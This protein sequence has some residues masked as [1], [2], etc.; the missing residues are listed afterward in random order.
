MALI[1]TDEAA[2]L[3]LERLLEEAR[4]SAADQ[5]EAAWQL[6]V[7]R[8]EEQLRSGWREHIQAVLD[9][10]FAD[11]ASR[12]KHEAARLIESEAAETRR[13]EGAQAARHA[14]ARLHHSA[15]RLAAI[16]NL[17]Q[18]AAALT[19]GAC[20]FAERAAVLTVTS[21]A[22]GMTL[23][24]EQDSGG[25][26]VE[27]EI[28]LEEAPAFQTAVESGEPVVA[29]CG[30]REISATLESA[31]GPAHGQRAYLYPV[32]GAK[33]VV[34]V[35]YADGDADSVDNSALELLACLAGAVWQTR[36]STPSP[37]LVAIGAAAS[38]SSA[39]TRPVFS[40]EE[41]P[42]EERE[43][44][45]RAQR[46]ARVQ[47][48]ELRLYKSDAVKEGRAQCSLY[49]F[50]KEDIDRGREVFRAQYVETCESMAD[51]FHAELVRTLANDDASLLGVEYP[52]ALV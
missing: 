8:V 41:L 52:G 33:S 39:D 43:I 23:A 42:A 44:H 3:G 46:F 50:L 21:G 26:I 15:R 10:R 4:Q 35:L 45:M 19:E 51:Y 9:E 48:A 25:A 37:G 29:L 1:R 24:L 30:A 47:V 2:R 17:R 34:A 31:F 27:G 7:E 36:A 38:G 11:L 32:W 16:E 22:S 49:K 14:T 5:L 28:P 18:W 20:E 12:V 40:W 6:H 13:V